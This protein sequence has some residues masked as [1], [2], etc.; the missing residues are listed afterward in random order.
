MGN[1]ILHQYPPD[2]YYE[3][4]DIVINSLLIFSYINPYTMI[5]NTLAIHDVLVLLFLPLNKLGEKNF[6]Y[7]KSY[8]LRRPSKSLL[9]VFM[10]ISVE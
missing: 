10:R 8:Y 3:C 1:S 5:E 2:T 9:Y 4:H 6:R 7:K